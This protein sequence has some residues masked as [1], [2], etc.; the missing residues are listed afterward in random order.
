MTT[1]EFSDGFDVLYNNV[2]SNQAPGLDEY[3]KSFFLTKAQDEILKNYFNPKG[4]KYQEG[5]DD[6]AKRQI[7]F[8]MVLKVGKATLI[9]EDN[10]EIEYVKLDSDSIIYKLPSDIFIILNER[11]K[12]NSRPIL[13]I[14]INH[15]EYDRYSMKPYPFPT[16]NT[17]W[18][19][20]GYGKEDD[21]KIFIG[22]IIKSPEKTLSDSDDYTI[23]YVKQPDPI[24]LSS[25]TPAS[26]NGKDDTTECELDPILHQEILQRAV[27]LA[28]AAYVGDINSTV[29]MGKRSE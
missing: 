7:D 11:L 14:P 28:K 17:V 21:S 13:V 2:M 25:I 1:Q 12:L 9:Q 10:T 4:N 26:I 6:N 24:I 18:R 23:R 8:S 5:F 19:I 15:S 27:E 3:E 22:E 16:K 29:E 20:L